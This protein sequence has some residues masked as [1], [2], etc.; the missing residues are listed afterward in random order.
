M[1]EATI[2]ALYNLVTATATDRSV[3]TTLTE[4]NYRLAKQLEDGSNEMK[5]INSIIKK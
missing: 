1:D 4:A 2:G 3:V 5:D